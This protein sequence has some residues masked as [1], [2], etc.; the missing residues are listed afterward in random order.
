MFAFRGVP[1]QC[2]R[3]LSP[4]VFQVPSVYVQSHHVIQSRGD[5]VRIHCQPETVRSVYVLSPHVFQLRNVYV[6]SPHVLQVRSVY[7]FSPY[8]V[9]V[10]SVCIL[11]PQFVVYTY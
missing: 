11:S 1:V 7:V 6:L 9:Q 5:L 4:H 2:I 8:V 10:R 3:V